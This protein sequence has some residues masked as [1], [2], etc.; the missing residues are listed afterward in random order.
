MQTT[1]HAGPMRDIVVVGASQAGLAASREL[2]RLGHEGRILVLDG[3]RTGPYRRPE[4]SKGLLNGTFDTDS[5]TVPWPDELELDLVTGTVAERLDVDRRVVEARTGERERAFPYDGLVIAT[6]TGARQA[7]WAGTPRGLHTLRTLDDALR[8]RRDLEAASSIVIVGGGFIGLE[9]AAVARAL[10][11]D[12]V[13]LE[14]APRPLERVLGPRFADHVSRVHRDRGVDL[15]CGVA[16]ETLDLDADGELE[17]VVVSD[18]CRIPASLVLFAAGSSPATE[19]LR[20]SGAVLD[21][22]VRC[23]ATCAVEGIPDAVAAGDVASWWNPLYGRRMRVE[24]WTNAIEQGTYA[25]RRLLGQ[26]D[27]EG[28]SSAPYFWSDQFGMR[29]QSIGSTSAHD[30]VVVLEEE[31]ETMVVGYGQQG[32][33]VA[34]AG[35]NAGPRVNRF[36][37]SV[38][39][40]ADLDSVRPVAAKVP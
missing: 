31:G 23:D 5:V 11:K 32:R 4:V 37:K 1:A 12:A 40:G 34:V 39:G 18:G 25:A 26:H 38:L 7:P 17:A 35:M 27:P 21:P 36:R 29:L 9:V 28:F 19:W 24:H 6:G 3:E 8:L 33:L 13:V 15:R 10:G 20:D 22:G 30:E 16:V 14:A 2:R